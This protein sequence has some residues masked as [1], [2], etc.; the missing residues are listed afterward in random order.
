MK[1]LHIIASPR[2]QASRTRQIG[3]SFLDALKDQH[4][5]AE[6]SELDLFETDLPEVLGG[7]VDAKY[8]FMA[9]QPV[10]ERMLASWEGISQMAHDFLTY[11]AYVISC[12]M[13][14][15][16]IPYRLKHYIDVIIQA[17][18]SFQYVPDGI[19]G[20]VKGKKMYIFTAR[21]G[22]YSEQ[23]PFHQYDFQEN[24]LRSIFGF[25]GIYDITLLHCQP[26]DM[27]PN[28]AASLLEKAKQDAA[29]L[30]SGVNA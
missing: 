21:G 26:T 8:A 20:L 28:L 4:P 6:I 18:I 14:N 13:W 22:D 5:Q 30:A 10:D 19:E 3:Q 1:V 23:S 25:I 12:P 11:D 27:D 17:G 15:F 29:A 2:G 24:Y 16:T 7:A 9:Q